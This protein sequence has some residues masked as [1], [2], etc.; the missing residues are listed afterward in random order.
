M[1]IRYRVN[2]SASEYNDQKLCEKAELK[3]CPIHPEG[4]CGIRRH[5]T[6]TRKWPIKLKIPCWYCRKGHTLISLLPDFLASR[7]S[8]TLKDV[9]EVVLEAQKCPTLESA[10]DKIRPDIELPGAVRWLRRRIKYVAKILTLSAGILPQF[11]FKSL[12]QLQKTFKV[13]V[14]LPH[15][16]EILE[17]HLHK[18]PHIIGLIPPQLEPVNN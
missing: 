3:Q 12:K 5:S 10:A 2:V 8:G 7:L 1:Q 18:L 11:G 14:V 17:T 16:R 4:G 6:Y 13:N 15:L 9:E